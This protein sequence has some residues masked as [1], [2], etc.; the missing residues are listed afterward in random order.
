VPTVPCNIDLGFRIL[1]VTVCGIYDCASGK[2]LPSH[3]PKHDPKKGELRPNRSKPD[4]S[5]PDKNCPPNIIYISKWQF[6]CIGRLQLLDDMKQRV[7]AVYK[8]LSL[9]MIPAKTALELWVDDIPDDFLPVHLQQARQVVT[10]MVDKLHKHERRVV[11]CGRTSMTAFS[12]QE[13]A[14]TDPKLAQKMRE[15]GVCLRVPNATLERD[16]CT[17]VRVLGDD[18][19]NRSIIKSLQS[20]YGVECSIASNSDG[21]F[22]ELPP[23]WGVV[24]LE[25]IKSAPPKLRCTFQKPPLRVWW[26]HFPTTRPPEDIIEEA[27][28]IKG[29]KVRSNKDKIKEK[30]LEI[31]V[32]PSHC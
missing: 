7:Q 14:Q 3:K 5:I 27:F 20:S 9:E 31:E 25:L 1:R 4:K 12:E 21:R 16:T 17:L 26:E 10:Q 18:V 24:G 13:F 22:V 32:P 23:G 29:I 28:G 11:V 6:E 30:G 15:M 2:L 19:S 8:D